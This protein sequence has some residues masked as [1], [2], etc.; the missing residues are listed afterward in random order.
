MNVGNTSDINNAINISEFPPVSWSFANYIN[1]NKISFVKLPPDK[2]KL[3]YNKWY[4]DCYNT[5]DKKTS[6]MFTTYEYNIMNV[7][8][9]LLELDLAHN[10]FYLTESTKKKNIN[11]SITQVWC[12]T[13]SSVYYGF[14]KLSK[15]I[16][17]D[18]KIHTIYF[19][20]NG[21]GCNAD[22]CYTKDHLMYEDML[23]NSLFTPKNKLIMQTEF[24][25]LITLCKLLKRIY[26]C[27]YH[28]Q[29]STTTQFFKI[30]KHIKVYKIYNYDFVEN[31]HD[32]I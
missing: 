2:Q 10:T 3:I 4:N 14:H 11:S 24:E 16:P 7:N 6:D 1:K 9:I 26:I 12:E 15:T 30:N 22:D 31:Y 32:E 18:N 17:K 27:G 20:M 19:G 23:D 13:D 29:C 21:L 8:D 5:F 25:K 28:F